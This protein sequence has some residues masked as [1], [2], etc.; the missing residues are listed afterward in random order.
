MNAISPLAILLFGIAIG[1]C[2]PGLMAHARRWYR[3]MTFKPRLLR[4]DPASGTVA[5]ARPAG[6]RHPL[7]GG[8]ARAPDDRQP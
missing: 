6:P 7:Q 5:S 3:R 1:A 2:L 4:L 8:A